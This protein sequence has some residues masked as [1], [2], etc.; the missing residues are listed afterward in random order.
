MIAATT[1]FVKR[2]R[3]H[4]EIVCERSRMHIEAML[5]PGLVLSVFFVGLYVFDVA[6]DTDINESIL[7]L[8]LALSILPVL[9]LS[10]F[11]M[12]F[13][14]FSSNGKND[15]IDRYKQLLEEKQGIAAVGNTEH[16][17]CENNFLEAQGAVKNPINAVMC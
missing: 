12:T 9:L 13:R 17:T 10:I 14:K 15:L 2:D 16:H 5:L 4:I 1:C 7:V 6:Y 3:F 8:S 11:M